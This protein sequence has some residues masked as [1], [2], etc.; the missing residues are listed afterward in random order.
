MKRIPALVRIEHPAME[1]Y[2]RVLNNGVHVEREGNRA[3]QIIRGSLT[4]AGVEVVN[5][6]RGSFTRPLS[7]TPADRRRVEEQYD[8][9]GTRPEAFVAADTR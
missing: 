9:G 3:P 5:V 1:T 7:Q 8:E 6:D 4:V 2:E